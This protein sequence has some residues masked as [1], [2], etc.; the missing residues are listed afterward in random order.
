MAGIARHDASSIAAAPE[1]II[2]CIWQ[3]P[4]RLGECPL[5]D[6]RQDRLFWI[7]SLARRIW[8]ARADGRDARF[9]TVPDV[10]GSIGLCDD[11]RLIAGFRR[12]FGL[13]DL[14][15]DGVAEVDWIGDPDPDQQDTRL[16]D[17]KVDR[18]GRFWC[19]SMNQDFSAPNA[20]LYRLESD[21]GWSKIDDGFTVSN[22]IAFSPDDRTLYFSDSRK[23]R[24]YRYDLDPITGAISARRPFID[25]SVYDG[26]IDG[27]TVDSQG[28]YWGALFEGNAVA[29]FSPE[30]ALLRRIPVPTRCPTM[31]SFGGPELDV[32]FVTS[33][34]FLLSDA[35]RAQDRMAGGLFAIEG[36]GVRGLEEPR[37]KTPAPHMRR[38]EPGRKPD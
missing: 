38:D 36:L 17:G 3:G 23:D 7:D 13:V 33:A 15:P 16:N 35:D 29:Q 34:T 1:P 5:W 2:T 21:L 20:A 31:C 26:R 6:A 30:G 11:A 9:W 18:Q 19:G 12:G 25:T 37:F 22:G 4:A 28:H 32:L 8:S 24:S 10:I 14:G 27:A